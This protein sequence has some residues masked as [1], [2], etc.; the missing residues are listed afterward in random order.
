MENK[1]SEFKKLLEETVTF[2]KNCLL[3]SI[4]IVPL[5]CSPGRSSPS[6]QILVMNPVFFISSSE[7]TTTY[8]HHQLFPYFS[9]P[10]QDCNTS[11]T[12][13]IRSYVQR[14]VP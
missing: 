14:L 8:L 13:L 9:S 12:S 10:K 4:N 5:S 11:A 6:V 1:R 2:S 3:Y 7:G